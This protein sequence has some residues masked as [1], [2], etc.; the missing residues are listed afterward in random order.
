MPLK[1]SSGY[2]ANRITNL[3]NLT[4]AREADPSTGRIRAALWRRRFR[5]LVI[6]F[7][8]IDGSERRGW[9]GSFG[10]DVGARR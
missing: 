5:F 6:S 8:E 1:K 10:G 7:C 2:L 9:R 4:R 3:A